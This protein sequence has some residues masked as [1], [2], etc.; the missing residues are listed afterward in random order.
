MKR[1]GPYLLALVVAQ[2]VAALDLA[3]SG[4]ATQTFSEAEGFASYKLP[5]GPFQ[6]G[7]IETLVAEGP[8][9][10]A[11]WRV[12]SASGTTLG[13]ADSLRQQIEAVGF[14]LLYEC[15][16]QECGGF[17]FRFQT[18]VLPE[19]DMHIDLG[20]YRFLAAQRLG[21]A[22]PEYLSL[23]VSRSAD[24]G[25]VQM[26]LV[27]GADETPVEVST[28]TEVPVTR[29]TGPAPKL[30][31]LIERLE[32]HGSAVLQDLAFETGSSDMGDELSPTMITLVAYLIANPGRTIA[33]VGH[34]DSEGS[35]R[36][37]IELSRKRAQA[38]ANMLIGLGVSANQVE[39]DGVGYL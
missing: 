19:P 24:L 34:T 5:I 25:Y 21:G 10:Q 7:R 13:V 23:F 30:P 14:E 36:G 33:M 22:V 16:T 38:A 12:E 32:T 8:K 29:P 1:W 3:F 2:P 6:D 9:L 18:D 11:A 35:L 20:D 4:P 26:I 39:A 37:N 17:D 27:G 28:S 15:E 31:P